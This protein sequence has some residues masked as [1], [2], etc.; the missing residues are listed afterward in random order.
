VT[1]DTYRSFN[2]RFPSYTPPHDWESS[3]PDDI[4]QVRAR[5]D[6]IIDP[7][8]RI[9]RDPFTPLGDFNR[10]GVVSSTPRKRHS[11]TDQ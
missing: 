5:E 2:W 3:D 11:S 8:V 7:L 10:W 4:A 9:E 6:E 1:V